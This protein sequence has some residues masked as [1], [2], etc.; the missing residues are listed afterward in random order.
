MSYQVNL[1]PAAQRFLRKLRD[2]VL[3]GRLVTALRDL[4][5]NPRPTG[6]LK[7]TGPEGFYRV[8]VG[9]YR[10]I[11][12]ILDDRLLVLVVDIGHRRDIYR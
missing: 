3:S 9:G 6:C 7:M 5:E 1:R 10:I 4:A 8:R 2:E 12:Q 11:Y